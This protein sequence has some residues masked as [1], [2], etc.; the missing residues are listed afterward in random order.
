MFPV[1]SSQ[2]MSIYVTPTVTEYQGSHRKVLAVKGPIT[3]DS[4]S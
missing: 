3:E 1:F 2:I 4:V